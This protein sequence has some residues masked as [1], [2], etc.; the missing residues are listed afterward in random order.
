[1]RASLRWLAE[2]VELPKIPVEDLAERLTL[3]GL[4]VERTETYAAEGVVVGRVAASEP[5]PKAAG[6]SVCQVEVGREG[7]TV[8]C[9]AANVEV[10][11]LVPLAVPGA[12][13]PGGEVTTAT[14]RGVR[15]RGMILSRQELGLEAKSGGIWN[16][17]A[18]LEAGADLAPLL[19]FPDTVL[20][21]KITSN[22]PDL[23]GL[24]GIARE[25]SALFRTDLREPD[26]AFPEE[27]PE[28]GALT[29]VEVESAVDCPRYIA[30]LVLD[31][32]P[33]AS[34]LP[35]QARLL[36]AGMRPLTFVVD[37]TNYV[38]LEFGHPLHAFDH[39]KLAEG[40]IVVRRARPGE[41]I[42][43]LDGV[44]RALTTE[45]LVIADG[46]RPVAVAG[47]M[48]GA[49]TEVH[50]G[51]RTVL[52]EAASF[53]P[54]RV[55]RG[56]RALGLRTEA[57]LRFERDLPPE[58]A[59]LASRRCC[60]LFAR[61]APVRIA[62]GAVDAYLAPGR[63]PVVALRK[64]RLNAV[65]GTTV[66]EA[67]VA[68][69]LARL[70]LA[71]EDRGDR[72]E[73]RVP[74]FRRDLAREIDL[75][76]EVA[77]LYGYDRIPAV[78]PVVAPRVGTKE[79]REGFADRVREVLVA[80]GLTEV[81]SF[82]LV[83][84]GEAEVRLRNPMAQGQDGLRASLL[85]G[86]LA[87]VRENLE[88]QA[89]GVALFEV[90]RVFAWAGD[91][92]HEDERVGV[93]LAGRPPTP[94]A[95]KAEYAPADLKGVLDAL[96]AALRVPEVELA[97]CAD[98]RLH[99]ARRASVVLAG[100]TVGWLGELAPELVQDLPGG[101]RALALELEL[102][103]LAA[104]ARAVQYKPVPRSPAAR[105]DLSLL[106]PRDVP[107][108]EVRA[109]IL[110]EALVES[111][112]LYDLYQGPGVPA[113]Q[114]SLTYELAFRDPARTLSSEE[115]DAAVARIL[116]RLAALGARLRT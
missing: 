39:G 22:R 35:L 42:R 40:R 11:G 73:A 18:G 36:K 47:V 68:S 65:L 45:V 34:P 5:H 13:L 19:E 78:P 93:A 31:V 94:L 104:A 4:E 76:E 58:T 24:Y 51:T 66:P 14:I 55:R 56:G 108:G 84:A 50:D 111:A 110:G 44:D 106:V 75:I 17:P 7:Y 62:R 20:T 53:S 80:L 46:A 37:V 88:S 33:W 103:P 15:S 67:E 70:G 27:G 61:H 64:A 30:R 26:L 16:L 90:G 48:G 97:P 74:P 77:R 98:D 29:A 83:P 41:R 112:F 3:A 12:R 57:S 10:G 105:R 43:T 87:A 52:L 32:R 49:D 63:T 72:W 38:M 109:A 28:A 23:L 71:V 21:L 107:E 92:V 101:R 9:G 85:P 96:L 60:A 8:V 100:R 25:V 114:I 95:G 102:A 79:P 82:G 86:L 54:A 69:G 81:Y 59:D 99:P 116:G 89:P 113:G 91:E 1:M 115:V 2:Y 6:L